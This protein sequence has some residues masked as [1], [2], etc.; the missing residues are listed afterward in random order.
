MLADAARAPAR[1]RKKNLLVG[2]GD[3]HVQ[4]L[5]GD[6]L[7]AGAARRIANAPLQPDALRCERVALAAGGCESRAAAR[8]PYTLRAMTPVAT[9]TKPTSTSAMTDRPPGGY[10]AL[11]HARSRAL[12]ARGLR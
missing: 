3:V 7:Q 9:K 11:R 6:R 5:F 4:T 2:L 10:S 8:T 12:R 1:T